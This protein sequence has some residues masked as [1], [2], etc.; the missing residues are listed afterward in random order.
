[1]LIDWIDDLTHAIRPF[2]YH[3]IHCELIHN[4]MVPAEGQSPLIR[5]NSHEQIFKS[6]ISSDIGKQMINVSILFAQ[7][8]AYRRVFGKRIG[9][10]CASYRKVARKKRQVRRCAGFGNR[11]E[12]G[13]RRS[14]QL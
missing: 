14:L 8:E 4:V 3:S 6:V 7:Q 10:A 12:S 1:M 9:F 2:R 5:R 11:V 13:N